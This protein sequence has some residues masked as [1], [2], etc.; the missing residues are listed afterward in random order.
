VHGR[1]HRPWRVATIGHLHEHGGFVD[2]RS[3]VG[4]HA[5]DICL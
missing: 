1:A 4:D 3:H 2:P 5:A